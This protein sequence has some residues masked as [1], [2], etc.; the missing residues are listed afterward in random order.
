MNECDSDVWVKHVMWMNLMNDIENSQLAARYVYL[1]YI[2]YREIRKPRNNT[3]FTM[4][5]HTGHNNR[6]IKGGKKIQ[7]RLFPQT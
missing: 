2:S 7:I 6:I 5:T 4:N 1:Y 3:L